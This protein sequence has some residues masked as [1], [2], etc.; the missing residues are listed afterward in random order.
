MISKEVN[1]TLA[2]ILTKN[3]ITGK[4]ELTVNV[5]H[6]CSVLFHDRCG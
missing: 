6:S 5:W 4:Q 2:L 1:K 3:N